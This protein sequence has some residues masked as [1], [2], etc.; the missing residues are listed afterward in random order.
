MLRR[1]SAPTPTSFHVVPRDSRSFAEVA[2]GRK[3]GSYH[4][5]SITLSCIQEVQD[6]AAN[7]VLVGEAKSFNI[8]CNFPSLV[9]LEGYEVSDVKY[10]RGM[11]VAEI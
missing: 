6:W 10:F 8:L 4:V 7:F 2:G 3:A 5:K 1:A 9:D 11:I